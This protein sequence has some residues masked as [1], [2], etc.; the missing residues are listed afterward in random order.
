MPMM[1]LK[2][3]MI[4][5]TLAEIGK[6]NIE[7]KK[8][9]NKSNSNEDESNESDSP[10]KRILT[11][12]ERVLLFKQELDEYFFENKIHLL[13]FHLNNMSAIIIKNISDLKNEFITDCPILK[14]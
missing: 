1:G 9:F 10:E 7:E 2:K 4:Y 5:S 11:L 3:T 13:K 8:F 6:N 14:N 12:V